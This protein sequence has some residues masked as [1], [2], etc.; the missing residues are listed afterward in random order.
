MDI[1]RAGPQHA[2]AGEATM[3][4][5][6]RTTATLRA[7]AMDPARSGAESDTLLLR[8]VVLSTGGVGYFEYEARVRGDAE[9]RLEVRL[10]QV[11]DVL[12]SIVVYDLHGVT[13]NITLPGKER[14]ATCSASSRS[15]R[16]RS[17]P[18][19]PC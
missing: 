8:R 9:L 2:S 15:T 19:P 14:C 12:K 16:A 5:G 6:L 17:S 11:D 1:P 13:G 18:R 7:A 3:N 10:D 4:H